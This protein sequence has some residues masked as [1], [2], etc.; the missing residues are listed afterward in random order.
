[1]NKRGS[2]NGASLSEEA[3]LRGPRVG[4]PPSLG[5]LEDMLRK[6]PDADISLHRGP[7]RPKGTWNPEG[8]HIPET[9]KDE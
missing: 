8:T 1:M 2:R 5:T 6:S 7:L 9:L 4:G 3:P